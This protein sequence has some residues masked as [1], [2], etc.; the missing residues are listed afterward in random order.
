MADR[1]FLR[2]LRLDLYPLL[3]LRLFIF[4]LYGYLVAVGQVETTFTVT[5]ASSVWKFRLHSLHSLSYSTESRRRFGRFK[6]RF[7]P[8]EFLTMSFL[9]TV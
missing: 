1:A 8:A 3:R 4:L 6:R 2:T 7:F 9:Q 5:R